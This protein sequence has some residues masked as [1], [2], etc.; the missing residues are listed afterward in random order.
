MNRTII[1][2]NTEPRF[3]GGF[4]VVRRSISDKGSNYRVHRGL[5]VG[6]RVGAARFRWD[7]PGPGRWAGRSR[8][9]ARHRRRRRRPRGSPQRCA[10]RGNDQSSSTLLA[11]TCTSA[12]TRSEPRYADGGRG[13]YGGSHAEDAERLVSQ[14][15]PGREGT[16]MLWLLA[17]GPHEELWEDPQSRWS[18]APRWLS[19]RLP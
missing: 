1:I 18:F 11:T 9:P 3:S 17:L 4:Q 6:G 16:R 19:P 13:S 7:G 2:L 12:A 10:S 14:G 5:R 8:H 15:V